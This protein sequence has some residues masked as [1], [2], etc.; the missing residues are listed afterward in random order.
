[1][2]TGHTAIRDTTQ[3]L[4]ESLDIPVFI[5]PAGTPAGRFTTVTLPRPAVPAHRS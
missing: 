4:R 5:A 1:M 2:P 3:R